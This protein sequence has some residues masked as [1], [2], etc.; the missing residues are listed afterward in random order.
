M[1]EQKLEPIPIDPKNIQFKFSIIH[2]HGSRDEAETQ[3]GRKI[4]R[5]KKLFVPEWNRYVVCAPYDVHFIFEIGRLA[6]LRAEIT[7]HRKPSILRESEQGEVMVVQR[8]IILIDILLLAIVIHNINM[9]SHRSTGFW[10]GFHT[11]I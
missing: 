3:E 7:G 1:A 4:Y 2:F 10:Q 6:L 9:V 8:R 5:Q 11:L